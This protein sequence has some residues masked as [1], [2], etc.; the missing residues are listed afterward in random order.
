MGGKNQAKLSSLAHYLK[1]GTTL[2]DFQCE[3]GKGV[4]DLYEFLYESKD[5]PSA[6][7]GPGCS[8]V[9]T[10]VAEA[11]HLWNVLMVSRPKSVEIVSCFEQYQ[12]LG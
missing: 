6:I 5:T 9:S 3:P 2:S 12:Q 7:L 4:K 8:S 10:A 1:S 11:A